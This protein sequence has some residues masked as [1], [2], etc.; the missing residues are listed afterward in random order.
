MK[1]RSLLS[2]Q[3]LS[4]VIGELRW[5]QPHPFHSLHLLLL[6]KVLRV[7][8]FLRM[9]LLIILS[10]AGFSLAFMGGSTQSVEVT[11][12]L[13]CNEEP[14]ADVKV[15][16]YDEEL[17]SVFDHKMD[18]E[19]TNQTGGFRLSYTDKEH[20][21]IDPKLYIYH[22]CEYGWPCDR[23]LA[24]G[25]PKDFVSQGTI[26]FKTFDIGIINLAGKFTGERWCL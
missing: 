11:G 5:I 14:A 26:P 17:F 25:I 15:E 22:R 10:L 16:L 23:K 12:R 8:C 20:S 6:L 13:V 1:T 2:S 19:R 24:I 3:S 18:E 4:L 9:L 21:T 7:K